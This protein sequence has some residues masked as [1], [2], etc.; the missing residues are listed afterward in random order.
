M[1][2]RKE[3]WGISWDNGAVLDLN[4]HGGHIGAYICKK[5]SSLY[6]NLMPFTHFTTWCVCVYNLCVCVF[7]IP[8][9]F[10]E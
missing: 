3:H 6:V 5:S 1:E 2:N 10:S 8:K 9:S 7:I 4:L